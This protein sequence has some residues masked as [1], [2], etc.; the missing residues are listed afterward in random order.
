MDD[1]LRVGVKKAETDVES[2]PQD[3]QPPRPIAAAEQER[4][5]YE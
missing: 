4:A 3:Q 5:A 2:H 1:Q